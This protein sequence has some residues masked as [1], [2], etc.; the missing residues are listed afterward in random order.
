M[1]L[2]LSFSWALIRIAN[3]IFSIKWFNFPFKNPLMFSVYI[4]VH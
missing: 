1:V 3:N 2:P 4:T